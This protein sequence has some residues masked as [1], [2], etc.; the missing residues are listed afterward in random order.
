MNCVLWEPQF[1]STTHFDFNR[2]IYFVIFD[3]IDMSY[4]TEILVKTLKVSLTKSLKIGNEAL[5]IIPQ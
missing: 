4:V 2:S 1:C 3:L 5:K